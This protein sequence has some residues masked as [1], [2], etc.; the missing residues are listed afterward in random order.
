MGGMSKTGSLIGWSIRDMWA[1]S[2]YFLHVVFGPI[3]KNFASFQHIS[4]PSSYAYWANFDFSN[5]E[6]LKLH[7]GP[8]YAVTTNP[9]TVR[10]F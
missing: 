9:R 2:L 5:S 4:W 1:D 3:C 8:I 7:L 10:N 6:A